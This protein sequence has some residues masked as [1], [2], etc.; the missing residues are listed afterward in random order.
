MPTRLPLPP[1][2]PFVETL[3]VSY[4]SASE[5]AVAPYREYALPGGGMHLVLRL[6]DDPI[7]LIDAANPAGRNYGYGVIGGAR[8][9][10]YVRDIAAPVCSIGATLRPGAAEVLFNVSAGELAE[11]HT[12]LEDVWGHQAASLRERLLEARTPERQL[13]LFEAFLLERLPAIRGMHPAIAQTLAQMPLVTDIELL[14]ERSGYSHRRFIELFRRAIGLTPK[15]YSRVQRFQAVVRAISK[16]RDASLADIAADAG[17]SDQSHFNRE[18]REFAGMTPEQ[19]R[20]LAP[21]SPSHVP[22]GP[23]P[24]KPPR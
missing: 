15:L 9:S 7:R 8:S 14:A 21:P 6:S 24:A 18:F 12:S 10:F 20:Q 13:D 22:A 11:R 3:W 1:L 17:Y 16:N 5:C 4:P 2:R 23:A 19:Y